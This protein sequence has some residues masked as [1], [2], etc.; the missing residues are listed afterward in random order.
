MRYKS[1][2]KGKR[3]EVLSSAWIIKHNLFSFHFISRHPGGNKT[4]S[5]T[6]NILIS[7]FCFENKRIPIGLGNRFMRWGGLREPNK[8]TNYHTDPLKLRWVDGRDYLLVDRF[9]NECHEILLTS[10]P[11]SKF[12]LSHFGFR[13]FREFRTGFGL[14]HR[15]CQKEWMCSM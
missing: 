13:D 9:I 8:T 11:D 14:K 4:W 2:R 7:L 12:R 1:F 6:R 15:A 3:N 5:K 10:L